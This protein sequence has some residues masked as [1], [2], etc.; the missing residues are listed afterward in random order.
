MNMQLKNL[1]G[2]L[3]VRKESL[4]KMEL[5]WAELGLRIRL[6]ECESAFDRDSGNWFCLSVMTGREEAVEKALDHFGIKALVPM[7]QSAPI[8]RRHKII[9]G[10]MVPVMRGYV[11]VN[12]RSQHPSFLGI[13]GLK[14]VIDVVGGSFKPM[15]VSQQSVNDF[16]AKAEGG[17]YDHKIDRAPCFKAGQMVT[18]MDGPFE[19][20]TGTVV[21]NVKNDQRVIV[22]V[23]M[24]GQVVQVDL[25]VDQVKLLCL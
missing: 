8:R 10:P 4:M 3:I 25:V 21:R 7:R 1:T 14:H 23:H 15:I 17:N 24:F 12:M 6:I 2:E 20:L 18:V 9:D 16:K 22:D 19:K 5:G 11:L 13:K